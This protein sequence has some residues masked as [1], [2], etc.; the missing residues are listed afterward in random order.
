VLTLI[1]LKCLCPRHQWYPQQHQRL[2][3]FLSCLHPVPSHCL[4]TPGPPATSIAFPGYWTLLALSPASHANFNHASAMPATSLTTLVPLACSHPLILLPLR[5]LPWHLSHLPIGPGHLPMA[6]STCVQ[7]AP[8]VACHITTVSSPH[9][10][11]LFNSDS[12]ST[13]STYGHTRHSGLS[14]STV[15]HT[16]RGGR[17]HA[18]ILG[19]SEQMLCKKREQ[20]KQV[21]ALQGLLVFSATSEVLLPLLRDVLQ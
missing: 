6:C 17:H 20:D 5:H 9:P 14:K 13:M 3:P 16:A 19:A 10:Q 7:H 18:D 12:T 11:H 15:H 4:V 8:S 2:I 21:Q 1:R